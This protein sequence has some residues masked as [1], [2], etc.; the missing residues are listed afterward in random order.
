MPEKS[1]ANILRNPK[2]A[3]EFMASRKTLLNVP[4]VGG[5]QEAFLGDGSAYR[6][7]SSVAGQN[8]QKGP[9]LDI[10]AKRF[11][12]GGV[13]SSIDNRMGRPIDL[14]VMLKHNLLV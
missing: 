12:P 3:I 5:V 9:G 8:V 7:R 4:Q 2:A 14:S 10:R 6:I 1:I 11:A 13:W